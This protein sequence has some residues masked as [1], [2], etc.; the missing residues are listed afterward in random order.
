M[1]GEGGSPIIVK[2]RIIAVHAG[3][4]STVKIGRFVTPDFIASIKQWGF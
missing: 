3:S 1:P 2:D 4:K